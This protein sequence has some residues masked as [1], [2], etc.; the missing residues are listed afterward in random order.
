MDQTRWR[1]VE[2]SRNAYHSDDALSSAMPLEAFFEIAARCNLRCQMCAINHDQRYKPR[3]GRP[4]FFEPELFERLEPI[5]P[6]LLRGYLFGLGEPLLNKHL[7]DYARQLSSA[8]ADVW[9]NT[10]ATLIDEE[11]AEALA[12]AGV[13]AITISIDGATAPTYEAIRVGARFDALLRGIRALA[14]ARERHGRP[15]L[16]FSFVAMASNIAELPALMELGHELGIPAV[17]VEP[18]YAQHQAELEI[19]YERENLGILDPALVRGIFDEAE[20]RGAALGVRLDS[21]FREEDLRNRFDYLARSADF[22]P[23]SK[24]SEPWSS[25]WVTSAGEVRTCCINEHVFGNL[26]EQSFEEIWNGSEY[27]EFR[28]TH[29]RRETAPGCANCIRNGRVRQSPWYAPVEPVT[30]RPRQR[31]VAGQGFELD[32]PS[33]GATITDPVAITGRIRGP[34]EWEV[35]L[36]DTP[37]GRVR[38][39]PPEGRFALSGAIPFVSEGAHELWA[40]R[41]GNGR[42]GLAHRDVHV[43]RFDTGSDATLVTSSAILRHRA[44]MR[45]WAIAAEIDGSRWNQVDFLIDEDPAARVATFD[46]GALP[47][48]R[49]ELM[50]RVNGFRTRPVVVERLR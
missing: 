34:E 3:A 30:Y 49:H 12:A 6:T 15:D 41:P 16:N 38:G 50:L 25:I 14:A 21:R 44:P 32:W 23:P 22:R 43:W 2:Q 9:F 5:F 46:L 20:E 11:K 31:H 42:G 35:M 13:A 17:H 33:A 39:N 7:P 19:H 45:I 40:R 47:P 29:A 27:L 26:F 18:L 36:D 4:P 37:L 8:G 28:R 24:C 48:G 1:N 10:N